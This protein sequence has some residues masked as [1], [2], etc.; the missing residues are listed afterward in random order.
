M[1]YTKTKLK[2]G[3]VVCGPVTAKTTYTRCAVCG[4]EIQMD[5]RELI[6]A[7][8]QDPYDTEVNC[9]DCTDR[10][11]HTSNINFDAVALLVEAFSDMGYGAALR[12]LF[13][14][15]DI[16]DVHELIPEECELFVDDLLDKV[17]E[18]RHD[19]Q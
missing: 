10:M 1:I 6:L 17:M 8:A 4:K 12:E 19:G 11:M 14:S 16:E 7:G 2:D 18:V 5:L 13:D 3:A 15:F 9:A